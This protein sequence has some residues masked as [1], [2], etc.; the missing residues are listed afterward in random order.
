M[1][2]R[3]HICIV[4][5]S[6]LLSVDANA[7]QPLCS[8]SSLC[9]NNGLSQT[10]NADVSHRYIVKHTAYVDSN[11]VTK[12]VTRPTLDVNAPQPAR[13][14]VAAKRRNHASTGAGSSK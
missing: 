11:E 10:P 12:Y 6:M 13:S 9:Q 7:Q 1:L 3:N 5:L 14:T 2:V 8:N 4:L